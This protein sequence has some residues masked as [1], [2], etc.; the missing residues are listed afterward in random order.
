MESNVVR[1]GGDGCGPWSLRSTH[2]MYTDYRRKHV[3]P[4]IGH[5]RAGA[6][7][8]DVLDSLYRELRRC[9]THCTDRKSTD[10]RTPLEHECDE[11]CR[12]HQCLPLSSTMVRHV[13]FV[14]RGAFERGVRWRWLGVNPVQFASPPAAKRPD[15]RPPSAEEAARIVDAAWESPDWGTLVWLTMTTG[16]RRGELCGLRWSPRRSAVR[17]ADL[18]TSHRPGRAASGGEGHQDPPAAAGHARSGDGRSPDRA[19]GALPGA[20]SVSRDDADAR[21]LRVLE[22]ARGTHASGAVVGDA[23]VRPLGPATRHRHAPAQPAALLGDRAHRRRRSASINSS[24]ARS[25]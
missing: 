5:P 10:H 6:V 25:S 13:H 19:L 7:D 11:R 16:A 4:F 21:R 15:P 23:A 20:C 14:L 3:R 24:K 1:T 2:R 22:I 8:N 12:P 18:P 9:R 17:R